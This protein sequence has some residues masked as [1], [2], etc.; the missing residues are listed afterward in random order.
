MFKKIVL[1][2]FLINL[3]C[4]GIVF[5]NDE[6]KQI[7]AASGAEKDVQ[8]LS[9]LS[10]AKNQAMLAATQKNGDKKLIKIVEDMIKTT[11]PKS[12]NDDVY[13]IFETRFDPKNTQEVLTWVQS[14]LNIK[15]RRLEDSAEDVNKKDLEAFAETIDQIPEDRVKLA[16]NIYN[17]EK[18]DAIMVDMKIDMQKDML[19][20]LIEQ[21]KAKLTKAELEQLNQKM[22][23]LDEQAEQLRKESWESLIPLMLYVYRDLS[24]QELQQ[25]VDFLNS[26]AGQNLTNSVIDSIKE[27]W[28]ARS[29][30]MEESLSPYLQK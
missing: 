8:A 11:S 10:E 1:L 4:V 9:Q 29:K 18:T 7:Y 13:K 2:V 17:L 15:L 3:W 20:D 28:L 30:K 12:F 26:S 21:N 24:D 5:S 6:L 16:D 19:N 23:T 14:R 22:R 25:Y 27:A